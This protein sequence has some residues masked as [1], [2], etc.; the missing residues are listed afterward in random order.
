MAQMDWVATSLLCPLH[1]CFFFSS[2]LIWNGVN[3]LCCAFL[4]LQSYDSSAST[5]IIFICINYLL[6]D[7]T[8]AY[9]CLSTS[10]ILHLTHIFNYLNIL[11]C[12][13]YIPYF[14]LFYGVAWN[15]N[16][17]ILVIIYR[18]KVGEVLEISIVGV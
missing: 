15:V 3:V 16:S 11:E 10:M 1:F 13:L 8:L 2:K 12:I 5:A 14:T 9:S 7:Y 18:N 4:H 6:V 17:E